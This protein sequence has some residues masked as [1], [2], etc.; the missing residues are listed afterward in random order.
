[1]QHV[2]GA[3]RPI[4]AA[5][6]TAEAIIASQSCMPAGRREINLVAQYERGAHRLRCRTML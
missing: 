4:L 6:A 5:S 1:M 3:R 2:S